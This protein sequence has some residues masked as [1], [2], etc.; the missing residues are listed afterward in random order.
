V[1][2]IVPKNWRDFQHYKDRNPP[3]IRL[4]R[5][6][7]DNKDFQRLPVASRAL[8][9]MLWLIASESVD[10]VINADPDDLAFRLRTTEKEISVALR[11][12]LEKG[13]FLPVQDASTPLAGR[14]QSAVPET[15]A[16]T[17]TSQRPEAL[18]EAEAETGFGPPAV[19]GKPR[20][21]DSHRPWRRS[22]M[23][24]H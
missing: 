19:A 9:P 14:L 20:R 23:S 6:L 4:H 17:E 21:S 10:G 18:T 2:K 22:P 3:W 13:F 12:L 24:Q 7:L 15:E 11:P 16:E 8:A 5:G 1:T